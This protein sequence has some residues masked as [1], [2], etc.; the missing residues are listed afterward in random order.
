[1]GEQLIVARC[2]PLKIVFHPS[3]SDRQQQ[4]IILTGKVLLHRFHNLVRSGKMNVAVFNVNRRARKF[5]DRFCSGPNIF[6]DNFVDRGLH[7][8][9]S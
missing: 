4:Q 3:G 7:K 9:F 6:V 1:M 8:T 5:T 2:F